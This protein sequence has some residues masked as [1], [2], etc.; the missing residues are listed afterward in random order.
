MTGCFVALS[1][2]LRIQ[3]LKC[4]Q[5]VTGLTQNGHLESN[6]EAL[7]CDLGDAQCGKG[8]QKEKSLPD[9][10]SFQVREERSGLVFVLESKEGEFGVGKSGQCA[11]YFRI[12][13]S[14]TTEKCPFDVEVKKLSVTLFKGLSVGWRG[15]WPDHTGLTREYMTRRGE[16]I[17]HF[18]SSCLPATS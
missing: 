15:W 18:A 10:R 5:S 1:S 3:S 11:G 4:R 16:T 12:N 8:R 9:T 7:S 17:F 2:K 13:I 6:T 14:M